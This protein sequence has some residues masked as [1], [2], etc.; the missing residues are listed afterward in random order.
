MR[1][2][3][4]LRAEAWRLWLAQLDSAIEADAALLR[5]FIFDRQRIDHLSRTHPVYVIDTV[6]RRNLIVRNHSVATL[7]VDRIGKNKT[8]CGDRS[9]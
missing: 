8:R 5:W 1:A 6:A 9:L 3:R 4:I 7:A 2:N